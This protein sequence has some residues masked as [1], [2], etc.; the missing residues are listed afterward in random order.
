MKY[1]IK[2]YEYGIYSRA[3]IAIITIRDNAVCM[4]AIQ[5]SSFYEEWKV[6]IWMCINSGEK[7]RAGIVDKIR[8]KTT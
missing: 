2:L 5:F 8:K 1:K 3:I 6:L 4:M 7:F